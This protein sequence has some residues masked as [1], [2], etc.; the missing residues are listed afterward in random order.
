LLHAELLFLVGMGLYFYA[1]RSADLARTLAAGDEG[2]SI[3][4]G[5]VDEDAAREIVAD[6]EKQEE[7]RKAEEVR[8]EEES[9]HPP[10]QV[11]DLP[12]PREEH[13]PDSAKFVSEHDST[14]EHETKKY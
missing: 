3:D 7:A 11:V 12:A 2:P 1:P 9:V 10:G 5:M 8:K 6:L 4:V 14:V 13:R